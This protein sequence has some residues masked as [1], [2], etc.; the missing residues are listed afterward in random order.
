M[1][2]RQSLID[3][4]LRAGDAPGGSAGLVLTA[5][6][7]PPPAAV[8]RSD[9]KARLEDYLAALR[10][11]LAL[12]RNVVDRILFVDNSASDLAPLEAMVREVP[13]DKRVELMTFAGN[14]HSPSLGKAYGEFRLID[15]GL[16]HT[17][18]FAADDIVWKSTG[19][20]QIANLPEIASRVTRPFDLLCDLH[21]VPFVGSGHWRDN[22]YMDL[23][24]FA[25]R[26]RAY[27]D[28]FRGAWR[29]HPEDFDGTYLFD[30]VI[31]ARRTHRVI[32][33]FPIQIVLRGISGR[34]QREYSSGSQYAKD[35]V[36]GTI[37]RVAPWL[38]L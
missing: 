34:H 22:R 21:N 4:A 32:P 37:R 25:F 2:H 19:R 36:R 11:Y 35:K 23:R 31:D 27:D 5:T 28:L 30:R 26:R 6:L 14:D 17:T 16:A 8:S 10:H 12:R 38:W 24:A 20:L 7:T 3:G 13:H 1:S 15:H 33:R 9:P 18:L 29:D